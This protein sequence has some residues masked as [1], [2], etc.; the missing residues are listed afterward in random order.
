M[1]GETMIDV[2]AGSAATRVGAP[3]P[4]WVSPTLS[5]YDIASNTSITNCGSGEDAF[6]P[7]CLVES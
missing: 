4:A 3:K 7:F 6:A 5:D 1:P 2:E